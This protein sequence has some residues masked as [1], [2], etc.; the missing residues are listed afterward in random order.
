M[1]S[2]SYFWK[3][4]KT[5]PFAELVFQS[6]SIQTYLWLC[7]S[8]KWLPEREKSQD[9]FK[10]A[11]IQLSRSA[12]VLTASEF[13]YVFCSYKSERTK[14]KHCCK[15]VNS[16]PMHIPRYWLWEHLFQDK[17]SSYSGGPQK[18]NQLQAQRKPFPLLVLN[19]LLPSVFK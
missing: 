8:G 4:L 2:G 15:K 7:S 16:W 6:Y 12:N 14:T 3:L 5:I 1:K 18:W 10:S 13:P 19:H 9:L 17:L 11:S